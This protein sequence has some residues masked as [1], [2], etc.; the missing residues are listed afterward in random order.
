MLHSL[1]S[2]PPKLPSLPPHTH[3]LHVCIPP[4]LS[5]TLYSSLV[6]INDKRTPEAIDPTGADSMPGAGPPSHLTALLLVLMCY[7]D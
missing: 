2:H 5:G 1:L 7:E 4:H 3:T 6:A